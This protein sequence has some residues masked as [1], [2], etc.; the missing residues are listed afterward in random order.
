MIQVKEFGNVEDLNKWLTEIRGLM[1]SI[2]KITPIESSTNPGEL[3]YVVEY[4]TIGKEGN[5]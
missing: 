3:M 2:R 4:S 5:Q 1:L